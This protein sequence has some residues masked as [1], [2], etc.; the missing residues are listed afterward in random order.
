M[1]FQI[2]KKSGTGHFGWFRIPTFVVVYLRKTL[3]VERL[4]ST[5]DGSLF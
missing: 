4:A 5:V 1:G 2:G 3:F